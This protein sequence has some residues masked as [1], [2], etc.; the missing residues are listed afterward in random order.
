MPA[1]RR[2]EYF[3]CRPQPG[4][5]RRSR[6]HST[7][8]SKFPWEAA[9]QAEF[10]SPATCSCA[11]SRDE[12]GRTVFK[13]SASDLPWAASRF[14]GATCLFPEVDSRPLRCVLGLNKKCHYPD[15]GCSISSYRCP[16]ECYHYRAPAAMV[17]TIVTMT[18]IIIIVVI[19]GTTGIVVFDTWDYWL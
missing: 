4:E 8:Q 17:I 7:W 14:C 3:S 5:Q 15:F 19:V 12:D 1:G 16:G 10:P 9:P 2:Q 11:R 6:I 18:M 13:E